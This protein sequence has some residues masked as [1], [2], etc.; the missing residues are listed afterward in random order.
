MA[1]KLTRHD[2]PQFKSPQTFNQGN[3]GREGKCGH[4][5]ELD[6]FGYCTDDDCRH[7]RAIAAV[8]AGNAQML[9]DGT[10]VWLHS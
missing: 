4:W 5:G 2:L 9:P 3:G 8:R 1:L 6:T 7:R 10:F